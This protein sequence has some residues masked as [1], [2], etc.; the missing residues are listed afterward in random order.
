[1]IRV[2]EEAVSKAFEACRR[3]R[4]KWFGPEGLGLQLRMYVAAARAFGESGQLEHFE[5]VYQGLKKWKVG[6]A[7]VLLPC[8]TVFE[9]LTGLD[10]RLQKQRLSA[11][12]PADWPMVWDA[13]CRLKDVK[14]TKKGEPRVMAVSK[15]LHFWNPRLFVICDQEE[16]EGFVFGHHWLK[17][18]CEGVN[19]ARHVGEAAVAR[20][21]SLEGYLKV[22]ALASE[23]VKANPHILPEFAWTVRSLVGGAAVPADIE[24]YEATAAEW[25]LVGLAE[26]PPA[27]VEMPRTH[28]D[29]T[30]EVK[31]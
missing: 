22:L 1:M 8:K 31:P 13:L 26:M 4:P 6:R 28:A 17:T 12:A 9:R 27:G 5:D 15:F 18:Q 10:P 14:Q 24:T 20:E 21:P 25:C 19:V 30:A 7:G 2:S 3:R 16:V 29:R 23:F 11:L